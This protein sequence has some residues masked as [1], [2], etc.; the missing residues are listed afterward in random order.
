MAK[1]H[2]K[3]AEPEVSPEEQEL[4]NSL[5][6]IGFVRV[7][8]KFMAYRMDSEGIKQISPPRGEQLHSALAKIQTA[9]GKEV[10]KAN[11]GGR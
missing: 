4:L 1:K 10:T 2:E 9:L 6:G 3:K 5:W 11:R 7:G 8:A